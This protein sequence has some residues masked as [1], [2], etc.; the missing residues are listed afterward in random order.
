MPSQITHLGS[1]LE[2]R[3]LLSLAFDLMIGM[4]QIMAVCVENFRQL[5][6]IVD[7]VIQFLIAGLDNSRSHSLNVIQLLIAGLENSRSH[8]RRGRA[9][10]GLKSCHWI[11][12]SDEE[13]LATLMDIS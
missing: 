8:S 13:T 4:C 7:N 6:L 1:R 12:D 2:Y 3:L 11:I 5:L 9:G 10:D